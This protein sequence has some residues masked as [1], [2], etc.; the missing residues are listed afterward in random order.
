MQLT[1]D[2]IVLFRLGPVAIRATLALTWIVM[3]LLV[4]V[5]WSITRRLGSDLRMGRGQNLLEVLV[6][7]VRDQIEEV[8]P[9]HGERLLPFVGTLFVFIAVANLLAVVPGYTPPTASLSTTTAL[10]LCVF[11]A[12]PAYG[13]QSRGL[14][15]YLAEYVEPSPLMLPFN[16]LGELTRTLALAVRLFGNIMSG[17]MIAAILVA[18]APL[19]FP[20]LMQVLGLLTGLVQAYVFAILA[21]IYVASAIRAREGPPSAD[22]AAPAAEE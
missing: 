13:V 9:G 17:A 20:I 18:L 11:V 4:V 6:L 15:G 7:A 1:P 22:A 21:L 16:V 8:A 5:S 14:R 12:V 19:F 10:A 2:E 3:A